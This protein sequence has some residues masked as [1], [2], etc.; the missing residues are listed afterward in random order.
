MNKMNKTKKAKM[1][2][3]AA[4]VIVVTLA[5]IMPVTAVVSNDVKSNSLYEQREIQGSIEKRPQDT[6]F[7]GG[8]DVLASP[9]PGDDYIPSITK[10]MEG[11][12]VVTWT[13]E[14]SFSESN[15]GVSYSSDPSDPNTW[16]DNSLVLTLTGNDYY[17]D[18]AYIH[19][20]VPDEY[21][22]LMGVFFSLSE[23][24][25]GY[26]EIPDITG[27]FADWPVYTWSSAG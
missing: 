11:H 22:G 7:A 2:I 21:S 20:S 14:Q 23:Q 15:W 4:L 9:Y 25:M 16:Y 6:T 18:T 27:D 3:E 12:I 10:D 24:Q 26:Y 1:F 13:N 19:S 17:W 5:L 8:D